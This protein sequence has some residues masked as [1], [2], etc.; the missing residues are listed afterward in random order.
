MYQNQIQNWD[1]S[2]RLAKVLGIR[3]RSVVRD[4]DSTV[5]PVILVGD[6]S[7]TNADSIITDRPALG[8]VQRSNVA[9]QYS[10]VL[11]YNPSD[12]GI[13]ALVEEVWVAVL[14]TVSNPYFLYTPRAGSELGN[15]T[16]YVPTFIHSKI[17]G[18]PKCRLTH[19]TGAAGGSYA[20]LWGAQSPPFSQQGF[21]FYPQWYLTPGNGIEIQT[22][23][24]N[25][26]LMASFRW[27][28]RQLAA[29]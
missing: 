29:L 17:A 1:I 7:E 8:A 13:I 5:V 27:K 26:T 12:S 6:V 23:D 15:A 4:C 16:S 20:G 2:D 25:C 9:A 3:D 10:K 18:A 14:G 28:E 21:P 24:V 19:E 11:I 22:V